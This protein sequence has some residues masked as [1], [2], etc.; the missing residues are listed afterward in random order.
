MADTIGQQDV[1]TLVE[2]GESL[3]AQGDLEASLHAFDG[4]LTAN[5][6]SLPGLLGSAVAFSQLGMHADAYRYL[7]VATSIAPEQPAVWRTATSVALA[8]GDGPTA[9][10]AAVQ[11]LR[12]AGDGIDGLMDLALAAFFALDLPTARSAAAEATRVA[13]D[14]EAARYWREKLDAIASEHELLVEVGRAHC[15]RGRYAQGL[16]LFD[17]ALDLGDS[18]DARLYAGRALLE[19]GT[20]EAAS[21]QF[22]AALA[23]TPGDTEALAGLGMAAQMAEALEG[24]D[25]SAAPAPAVQDPPA[26]APRPAFCWQCGNPLLG[27]AAF[28]VACGAKVE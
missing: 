13:P 10:E 28:C 3:L 16:E 17:R 2:I 7:D 14:D 5:A 24:A 8:A 21:G 25:A 6:T 4:V 11:R 18:F 26:T 15:R 12:L 19:L 27:D 23:I 9:E 20:P 1:A 22:H